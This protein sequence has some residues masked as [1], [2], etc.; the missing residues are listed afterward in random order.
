MDIAYK[1]LLQ[2]TYPSWLYPVKNGRHHYLGKV[3][4]YK[5]PTV[6]FQ[7]PSMNFVQPLCLWRHWRLDVTV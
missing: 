3:G 4:W 1:L 5:N 6:R 2:E 7:V